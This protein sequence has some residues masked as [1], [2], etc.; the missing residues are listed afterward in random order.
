[1]TTENLIGVS[2][3]E[4]MLSQAKRHRQEFLVSVANWKNQK[5]PPALK[6]AFIGAAFGL[7]VGWVAGMIQGTM[8]GHYMASRLSNSV[9][10]AVLKNSA[11]GHEYASQ[12]MLANVADG[13]VRQ[14]VASGSST[15]GQQMREMVSVWY[16]INR[17]Q[18]EPNR[19]RL[20]V[21]AEA[22]LNLPPPSK[23]T[24]L[25]LE[26]LNR[27]GLLLQ[28]ADGYE[29]QAHDYSALLGR[30][31]TAVQLVSDAVLRGNL[32]EQVGRQN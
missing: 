18:Q 5:T 15:I 8:D 17:G 16:W 23:E 2:D 1:M 12:H 14:Y 24:L 27:Q 7:I 28:L 25:Q 9:Y 20:V 4:P 11:S 21:L 30:P 29:R 10:A 19:Q 26:A 6:M 31:V 32:P 13:E 22:R 3:K